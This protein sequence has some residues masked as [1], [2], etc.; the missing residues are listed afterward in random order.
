MMLN[1]KEKNKIKRE[2]GAKEESELSRSRFLIIF[3]PLTNST[4]LTVG[5]FHSRT[6]SGRG[7]KCTALG[8]NPLVVRSPYELCVTVSKSC[9]LGVPQFS[10]LYNDIVHWVTV[11]TIKGNN[12]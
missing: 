4:A 11:R 10:R 9:K 1:E 8:S 5:Q 3:N 6:R 12:E 7:V 2:E